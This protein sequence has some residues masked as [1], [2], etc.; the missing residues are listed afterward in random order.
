[1]EIQTHHFPNGCRVVFQK[2]TQSTP[3]TSLRVFCDVGSAY[4]QDGLRG[5]SHFVEHMC[6]K[7][8]EHIENTRKLLLQYNEM[9]ASFNAYTDKRVTYFAANCEDTV[10]PRCIKL[11]SDMM[12]H[13]TFPKKEF[14]KEQ[15]VVVEE[16]IRA[17]DNHTEVLQDIMEGMLFRGSSYENQV[18]HI[19]FHRRAM[20][21]KDIYQWY[22]WFYQPSNII[23]SIVSH[24]PFST[25]LSMIQSSD[26]TATVVESD[27]PLLALSAPILALRPISKR[28]HCIP[29]KGMSTTMIQVAFRTCSRVSPDKHTL[30][31][32]SMV[33]RGFSGILFT[34]FRTQQ[35]LTYRSECNTDY[36]E[37]AGYF[38]IY[39]QTD[40]R[41]LLL[42][43]ETIIQLLL[44][45]KR[46]GVS[47]EELTLAKSKM[48]GMLL[49]NQQSMDT[50]AVYNGYES[51]HGTEVV[52]YQELYSRFYR[53][54]TAQQINEV[55][56]TYLCQ[57]NMVVGILQSGEFPG[58][59]EEICN[60]FH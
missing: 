7:G 60:R 2:S 29:K 44:D 52:P 41:K 31:L 32:L 14:N 20:K 17:E 3:L 11:L 36:Y 48:K 38:S 35:G 59:I 5:V 50:I 46:R 43:L 34:V 23:W 27:P 19:S 42:V 54:I 16:N 39:V 51:I 55:I 9:G 24:L 58:R 25:L 49:V 57:E 13:S 12:L 53:R 15:K 22:R 37:H 26:M 10:V 18:D 40:P 4:E 28:I 6:F 8:T 33:L 30:N 47:S 45:L 21:E 1:M 56:Q